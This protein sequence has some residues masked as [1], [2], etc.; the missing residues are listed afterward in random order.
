M[1]IIYNQHIIKV[2]VNKQFK[3]AT[4]KIYILWT[5]FEDYHGETNE[6]IKIFPEEYPGHDRIREQLMLVSSPSRLFH[7]L[8]YI[9]L[10][11]GLVVKILSSR[12][13]IFVYFCRYYKCQYFHFAKENFGMEWK[14]SS[15]FCVEG[16]LA[17]WKKCF[18]KRKMSDQLMY[19]DIEYIRIFSFGSCF[20]QKPIQTS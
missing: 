13:V 16:S 7:N 6:Y 10:P 12:V 5:N 19:L 2:Y 14:S 18:Y 11:L 15:S 20:V 4:I 1:Y 17:W 8:F 3:K 9:S